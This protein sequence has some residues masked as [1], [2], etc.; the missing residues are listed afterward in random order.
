[1]TFLHSS[2]SRMVCAKTAEASGSPCHYTAPRIFHREVLD[3]VQA[4]VRLP[5]T[6]KGELVI[7]PRH[8]PASCLRNAR[9]TSER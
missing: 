3:I 4:Q 9:S 7:H 1:M 5:S 2:S 6:N 8:F